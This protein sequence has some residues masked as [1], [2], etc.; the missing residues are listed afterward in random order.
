MKHSVLWRVALAPALTGLL[1]VPALSQSIISTVAG[2]E[3]FFPGDGK[4]AISAPLGRPYNAA[5]DPQGNVI[6]ADPNNNMV[7]RVNADGTITVLAGNGLRGFSGE[8]GP[9]VSASLNAPGAVVSDSNGALYIADTGNHRIRK[10]SGGVITTIAGTGRQAFGGDGGP[11]SAATLSA[12]QFLALAPNGDLLVY[13]TLNYV[14]RRI[15]PGGNIS[16][17][18]GNRSNL[19]SGCT[20]GSATNVNLGGNLGGIAL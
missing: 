2:T 8:G 3:W 20:T 5:I 9:A 19:G 15:T 13:D 12:P 7:M 6:F 18:A 16:T 1:A 17:F 4:P 10:V 11:A 14:I